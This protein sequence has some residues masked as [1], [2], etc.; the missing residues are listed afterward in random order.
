MTP[1]IQR[2][3]PTIARRLVAR[4]LLTFSALTI[5][6]AS[7]PAGAAPAANETDRILVAQA[8]EE[9]VVEKP[10]TYSSEQAD[11]GEKSYVKYC[12]ECHGEDLRGG[13]LG[14]PPLRGTSF[15]DKFAKGVP[16]GV[17]FDFMSSAMPPD[18]PGRYSA[19]VYLD[20]MAY[21][22]KRNGYSA[23]AP[24]PSNV[25]ELYNIIVTK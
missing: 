9:L 19:N 25:E 3:T 15:E 2:P 10:V 14:G 24:L 23:G 22:L 17:L 13:L 20:M 11:R 21:I 7:W 4:T 5:G 6:M 1:T 16:A 8:A 18:S 12:L